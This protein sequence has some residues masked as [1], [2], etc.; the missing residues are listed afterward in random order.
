LDGV[1]RVLPKTKAV[2]DARISLPPNDRSLGEAIAAIIELASEQ[3][4]ERIVLGGIP[5]NVLSRTQS[6]P[7]GC[8]FHRAYQVA[9]AA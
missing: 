7:V 8:W 4:H 9:A 1:L 3:T 2:L 6:C 5:V